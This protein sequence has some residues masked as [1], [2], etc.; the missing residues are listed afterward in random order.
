MNQAFKTQLLL[1]TFCHIVDLF[2]KSQLF[3]YMGHTMGLIYIIQWEFAVTERPLEITWEWHNVSLLVC[4][5]LSKIIQN[6]YVD[7]ITHLTK[8]KKH[9]NFDIFPRTKKVLLSL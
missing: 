5:I 7:F 1:I 2:K 6:I 3:I 4:K 8:I 9:I